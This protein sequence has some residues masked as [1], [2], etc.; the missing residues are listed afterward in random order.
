MSRAGNI[1]RTVKRDTSFAALVDNRL[2]WEATTPKRI[3]RRT[4]IEAWMAPTKGTTISDEL[5]PMVASEEQRPEEK[6][7]HISPQTPSRHT[8]GSWRNGMAFLG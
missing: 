6:R 7:K 4:D 2:N 8:Y 5:M 1:R 3:V